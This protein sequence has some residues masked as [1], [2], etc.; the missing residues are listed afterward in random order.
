MAYTYS[1]GQKLYIKQQSGTGVPASSF[2]ASDA[3]AITEY[4]DNISQATLPG[5]DKDGTLSPVLGALDAKSV[6]WR[7]RCDLRPSGTAGV[8]PDCKMLMKSALGLETVNAGT[9]V[10]YTPHDTNEYFLTLLNGEVNASIDYSLIWDAV[11]SGF[12]ANLGGGLSTIDF[13]GAAVSYVSSK[14]FSSLSSADKGTVTPLSSMPAIPASSTINGT[15]P[16]AR[17]GTITVAGQ[18]L[19]VQFKTASVTFN[20]G[21]AMDGP[22]WGSALSRGITRSRRSVGFQMEIV[23]DDG[24]Q[25]TTILQNA[26]LGTP[27][28]VSIVIGAVVGLR[29]TFTMPK[30]LL[31]NPEKNYS[32]INRGRT[33]VGA[34]YPTGSGTLDEISVT[35]S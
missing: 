35:W 4:S 1:A 27:I 9:S 17:T 29:C 7:M 25:M 19:N 23:D 5:N 31:A 6:G 34:G 15:P 18:N 3:C 32:D 33:L 13:N 12:T 11:C 26:L 22:G 21:K 30:V 14:A 10:V 28:A 20:S 2:A 24:A 8:P 16:A